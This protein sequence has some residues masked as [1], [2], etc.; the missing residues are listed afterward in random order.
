M[1]EER[2]AAERRS[3]VGDVLLGALALRGDEPL[4]YAELLETAGACGLNMSTVLAWSSRAQ[5]AGLIVQSTGPNGQGRLLRLTPAGVE[6]A[7]NNRRHFQRRERWQA[8][9]DDYA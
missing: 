5:E 3:P 7:R 8:P 4:P 9:P 1:D 6:R 2:R